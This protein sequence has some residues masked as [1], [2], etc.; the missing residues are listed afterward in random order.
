MA[1][2]IAVPVLSVHVHEQLLDAE[3][4]IGVNFVG[5]PDLVRNDAA[6]ATL[7]IACGALGVTSGAA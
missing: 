4:Q 5:D 2:R 1:G 7:V 3:A 6:T